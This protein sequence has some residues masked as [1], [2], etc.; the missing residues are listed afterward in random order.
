MDMAMTTNESIQQRK[1]Q[2][3]ARGEGNLAPVYVK[4][5]LNAELWDVE[6][7]RY[8][9]FGAGIAVTNTGHSHPRIVEA[10][11]QQIDNFSHTCVMVTPYESAVALAEQL[12][13][14]APG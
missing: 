10:V 9:D 11:K 7:K 8:I 6:D 3:I 14:I 13:Q 1:N 12:V 4:R 2:V 5:A